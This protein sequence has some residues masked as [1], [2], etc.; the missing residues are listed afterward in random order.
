MTIKELHDKAL[1]LPETPGVYIMKN[2]SLEIIYIGKAK[3]LKNRVSSYFTNVEAHQIKVLR[4]IENVFEFD[5]ILTKSEF[6]ALILE[7][8][9]IKQHKPKYNILLK[10]DKGYSYLK[11]TNGDYPKL[12]VS[13]R[14]DDKN[15]S[16][17]GPYMSSYILK[18]SLDEALK[19]FKLPSCNKSFPESFNK[20]KP[21]LNYHIGLCAAPCFGKMTPDEYKQAANGAI[22][23]LKG[24][25]KETIKRLTLQMKE[26][27]ENCEF[28]KAAVLRD[29]INSIK[30][31]SSKQNVISDTKIKSLDVFANYVYEEKACINIM[32]FKEGKLYD[33]EY[34]FCD[35]DDTIENTACEVLK[36]YYSMN[37]E[38]PKVI[39]VDL[40]LPD[41][42]IIEE[43]LGAK[44]N[45]PKRGRQAE[46]IALSKSNAKEKLL[47]HVQKYRVSPGLIE[48]SELLGLKGAPLRIESYDISHTMGTNVVCGMIVFT[49][50]K[51]DK[52]A[53]RRFKIRD[54]VPGD[55]PGCMREVLTRRFERYKNND[56]SFNTLPDLILL[57]GGI[58]Q[59]NAVKGV[60]NDFSLDIPVFGMVKDSKHKTRA[61]TTGEEEITISVKRNAFTLTTKIQDEVHRYAI[62][63]HK[64]L[65]KNEMLDSELSKIPGIG[66]SKMKELLNKYKTIEKIREESIES[67]ASTP[68]ITEKNAEDI[69]NFYH[70][71][72]GT[73]KVR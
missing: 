43:W 1:T 46:L 14:N 55:D 29:R 54:A 22:D 48:L 37:R 58:L 34:F 3:S 52:K 2:K 61:I 4:M 9:L 23:F 56:E 51:P 40:F 7:C 8:S 11:I 16:Y 42:E 18:E 72:N 17:I 45:V 15:S 53:Y 19:I 5:Y 71:D 21:C 50:A 47:K 35:V 30:K 13:F 27:S 73:S 12:S 31:L 38:I 69:Y 24:D 63:Y 70:I 10:D 60:L 68:K 25:N 57:D 62:S 65:R 26:Y 36:R 6:E 64:T 28:E 59:V 20:S 67:L 49:E 32:R 44:I 66:P 39:S 41:K 33:D